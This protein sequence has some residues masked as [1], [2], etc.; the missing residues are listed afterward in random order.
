MVLLAKIIIFLTCDGQST[1]NQVVF[2]S[3]TMM[4]DVSFETNVKYFFLLCSWIIHIKKVITFVI[5]L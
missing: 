5:L 4:T 3:R 2:Q 1:Q